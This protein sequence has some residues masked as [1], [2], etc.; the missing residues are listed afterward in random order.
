MNEIYE[1]IFWKVIACSDVDPEFC[2]N[3]VWCTVCLHF[4][5]PCLFQPSLLI[6][7]LPAYSNPLLIPT[8]C[9]LRPP[10][11]WN[12]RVQ[13]F[14]LRKE[15][16]KASYFGLSFE[17]IATTDPLSKTPLNLPP[18]TVLRKGRKWTN[19]CTESPWYLLKCI[20]YCFLHSLLKSAWF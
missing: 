10:L 4:Q 5:T 6:P 11:I 14:N 9:L 8:P 18:A 15:L 1:A 17:L 13:E 12:L 16:A 3:A 19:Y 2:T 20:T 7:A